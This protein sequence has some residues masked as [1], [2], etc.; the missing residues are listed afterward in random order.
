MKPIKLKVIRR[1]ETLHLYTQGAVRDR[2]H[3]GTMSSDVLF[4]HE[5]EMAQIEDRGDSLALKIEIDIL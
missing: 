1:G 2:R 4:D 5:G 3:V